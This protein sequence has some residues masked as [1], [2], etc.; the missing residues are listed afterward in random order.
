MDTEENIIITKLYYGRK[1]VYIIRKYDYTF[2]NGVLTIY[3]APHEESEG[4]VTIS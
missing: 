4:E 3:D 1:T 2:E